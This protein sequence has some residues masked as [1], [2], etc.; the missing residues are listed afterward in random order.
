[1]KTLVIKALALAAALLLGTGSALAEDIDIFSG[2]G[3]NGATPN[4][5]IIIDNTSSNDA[6]LTSA[7]PYTGP[8][9]NLPNSTLLN[10]VYCS[11][12]GTLEAIKTQP[13][14]LGKL[15]VGLMS[16]G[17]GS[18]KGGQMYYPS[19]SPYNLPLMDAA[20]IAAFENVIIGGIPKATGDAKLDG[21]MQEAWAWLTGNT[22][23]RSGTS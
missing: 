23:P 1:M 14:L 11:L 15:N 9:A 5:L 20:G 6:A 19:T 16:G 2:A 3:A 12:Y 7:C 18:N 4:V 13:A 17:S 22:G 8:P 21:D 10:M